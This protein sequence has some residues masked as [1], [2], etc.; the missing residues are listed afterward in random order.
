MQRNGV[1]KVNQ[2]QNA[3]RREVELDIAMNAGVLI[4]QERIDVR[5][6]RELIHTVIPKIVDKFLQVFEEKN[7][8]Y[9][10]SIDDFCLD[11]L[12]ERYYI[13]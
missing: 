4:A 6:S 3:K 5:D 11:E 7:H 13:E 2:N 9:L 12:K 10:E 1:F 8:N